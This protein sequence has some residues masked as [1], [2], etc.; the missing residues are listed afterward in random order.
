MTV[1]RILRDTQAQPEVTFY[2]GTTATNADAAVTVD[3]FRGDGS[4]FATDA[5]T[6][7]PP[8]TTGLYRYTLAP[9]AT[10]ELFTLQWEGTFGGVVQRIT[11]Q[12]EVVSGYVVSLADLKAESGMG[13]KTD[14]QL[15]E[16]RQWFE[17]LAESYCGV[18][19][20]PRYARELLDGDGTFELELA[21][22]YPRSVLSCKIGGVAQTG[23]ATWDLYEEGMIVRDTGS[24]AVGRRNVEI[25]YEH[26]FD[27][28]PSDIREA[29]L[30][31]VRSNVLGG[32]AG[33]GIPV[34]VT[35]LITD[36][37]TMTFGRRTF[38]FGIAEVD[39]ALGAR[40]VIP[41]G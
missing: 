9:Q 27:A 31:A 17:D 28:A 30:V 5:A 38:P 29:A 41:V 11:T 21:H 10:L 20:V 4:V 19:F 3:I 35:Q 22:P 39:T 13:T 25:I 1:Q 7:K 23:T 2:V 32:S 15:A 40:R 18:A 8:A 6:T 12:V 37:G 36:A 26:G 33:G 14:A 24:F 16:T 34:G